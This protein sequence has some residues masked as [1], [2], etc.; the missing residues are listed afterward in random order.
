[1]SCY[2]RNPQSLKTIQDQAYKE[3]N[4]NSSTTVTPPSFLAHLLRG[5]LSSEISSTGIRLVL[6]YRETVKNPESYVVAD[7]VVSVSSPSGPGNIDWSQ[8][9]GDSALA[10][11]VCTVF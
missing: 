1:M 6:D 5:N 9:K 2:T 8:L 3:W 11:Q 10:S 4:G 7:V